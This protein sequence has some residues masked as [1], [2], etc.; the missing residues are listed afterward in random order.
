MPTITDPEL[1]VLDA[2]GSERVELAL[3]L[4]DSART[5]AP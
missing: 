3:N 4:L 1:D 2:A 5:I